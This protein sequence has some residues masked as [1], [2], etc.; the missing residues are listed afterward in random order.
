M[1]DGQ[2]KARRLRK[3]VI[4]MGDVKPHDDI[5]YVAIATPTEQQPVHTLNPQRH[6][7]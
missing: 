3:T 6:Y 5:G 4:R 1:E 2:D 7:Y